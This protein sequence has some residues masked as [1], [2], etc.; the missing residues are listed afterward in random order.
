MHIMEKTIHSDLTS[1]IMS[2]GK[3]AVRSVL[4]RDREYQNIPYYDKLPSTEKGYEGKSRY[5]HDYISVNRKNAIRY[6]V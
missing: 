5:M 1:V 6:V 3:A 4:R 2:D